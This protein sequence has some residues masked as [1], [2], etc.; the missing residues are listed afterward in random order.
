MAGLARADQGVELLLA[1]AEERVVPLPLRR[2]KVDPL[3][4]V[5]PLRER[6]ELLPIWAKRRFG[7]AEHH[8]SARLLDLREENRSVI[9]C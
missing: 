2:W 1:L 5:G 4:V 8:P 7:T 3:D 6:D 9:F